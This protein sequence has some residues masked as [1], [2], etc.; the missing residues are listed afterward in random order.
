[1]PAWCWVRPLQFCQVS[2]PM[3]DRDRQCPGQTL[4]SS[5]GTILLR[6]PLHGPGRWGGACAHLL[7]KIQSLL[8]CSLPAPFCFEEG[9]SSFCNTSKRRAEAANA[10]R[11]P[12]KLQPVKGLF[13]S[14]SPPRSSPTVACSSQGWQ[15]KASDALGPA[16]ELKP[17]VV[18]GLV[19]PW[20][21]VSGKSTYTEHPVWEPAVQC[22]G[23]QDARGGQEPIYPLFWASFSKQLC[24]RVDVFVMRLFYW[25]QRFS[26][27][28]RP[29]HPSAKGPTVQEDFPDHPAQ[30]GFPP[31]LLPP[32][33]LIAGTNQ[34][35]QIISSAPNR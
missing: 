26:C 10:G 34:R 29:F 3:R 12:A 8:A 17:V 24:G 33:L 21:C 11:F 20:L 6:D 5:L 7:C 9:Q 30:A 18:M 4:L 14:L 19:C 25:K 16:K 23:W 28:P 27:M 32:S 15:E 1:M 35:L 22:A 2:R 31:A 13:D